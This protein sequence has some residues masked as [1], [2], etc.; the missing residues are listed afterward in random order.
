M[1]IEFCWLLTMK[2]DGECRFCHKFENPISELSTKRNLLILKRLIKIG[3]KKI[4]WSGG[5]ALLYNGIVE[6]L[7]YSH[8]A[9]ISNVLIT[10]GNCF[11]DNLFKVM[12]Y[13][14]ELVIS[15]DS[16]S[17]MTNIQIGRGEKH[18]DNVINLLNIV[19]N[20]YENKQIRI[21]TVFTKSNIGE[22]EEFIS[23]LY[24]YN[25]QKWRISKFIPLR[26]RALRNNDLFAIEEE[27][28]NIIIRN[29]KENIRG[30]TQLELRKNEDYN[31]LYII[32]MPNGNL[33]IT[34]NQSDV[35]LGFANLKV[36]KRNL[37]GYF[38]EV[39]N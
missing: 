22:I 34:Q 1:E 35:N 28:F 25:I 33:C 20:D 10:N 17:K 9:G 12:T 7:D 4:V 37:G 26:G 15:L 27:H 24:K 6:L 18:A 39:S 14:D 19:R 30:I 3:I 31:N 38:N 11:N 21:N 36:L 13:I 32:L 16:L 29:I 23:F 2:C 5:E 8:T